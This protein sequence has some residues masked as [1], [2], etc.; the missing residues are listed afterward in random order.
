MDATQFSTLKVPVLVNNIRDLLTSPLEFGK[1]DVDALLL[2]YT[3]KVVLII[4]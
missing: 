3:N 4:E 1:K 2:F